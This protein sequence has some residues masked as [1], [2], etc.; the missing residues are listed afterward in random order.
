MPNELA[1]YGN[2]EL[3]ITYTAGWAHGFFGIAD[4]PVTHFELAKTSPH[5]DGRFDVDLPMISREATAS[6]S[7]VLKITCWPQNR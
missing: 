1:R 5:A 4:G 3:V 2:A 6:D 7:A